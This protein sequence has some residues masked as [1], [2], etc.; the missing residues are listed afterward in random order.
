MSIVCTSGGRCD[1][2]NPNENSSPNPKFDTTWN[3]AKCHTHIN[4]H[5]YIIS[6][7][8][9]MYVDIYTNTKVHIY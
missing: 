5:V 2:R 1:I 9:N 3:Q 4:I 7:Q 8:V 6:I